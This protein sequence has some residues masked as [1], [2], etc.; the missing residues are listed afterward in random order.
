MKQGTTW[1]CS[2][3]EQMKNAKDWMGVNYGAKVGAPNRSNKTKCGKC[4]KKL[5]V[6][7]KA[8]RGLSQ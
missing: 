3:G 5:A 6:R 1:V 4:K 2:C 8:V 7:G